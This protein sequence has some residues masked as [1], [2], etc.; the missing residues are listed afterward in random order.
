MAKKLVMRG[1]IT[2]ITPGEPDRTRPQGRQVVRNDQLLGL[3]W[4]HVRRIVDD[5]G[6]NVVQAC[7]LIVQEGGYAIVGNHVPVAAGHA[8]ASK[9]NDDGKVTLCFLGDGAVASGLV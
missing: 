2:S 1:A 6:R 3:L 4:L 5:T 8:F 9:Y 7:D